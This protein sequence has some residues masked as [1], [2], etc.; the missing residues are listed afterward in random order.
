MRLLYVNDS[1]HLNFFNG[2]LY[3]V[4]AAWAILAVFCC[5]KLFEKRA[6]LEVCRKYVQ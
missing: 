2:L 6:D 1:T 5:C 4:P 3:E